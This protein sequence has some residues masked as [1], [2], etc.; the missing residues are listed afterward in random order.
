M[1]VDPIGISQERKPPEFS[2]RA[3][4]TPLPGDEA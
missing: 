3:I 2:V 4:F 1:I